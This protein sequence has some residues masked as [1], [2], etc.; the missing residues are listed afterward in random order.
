MPETTQVGKTTFEFPNATQLVATRLVKAPRN[1]VWQAH[2]QCEHIERWQIGAEGWWMSACEMDVR[3]G[4]SYRFVYSGPEGAGFQFT[5]VYREVEEPERLVNTERLDDSPTE[6]VNTLTL[7]EEEGGTLIR[8]VVDYPSAEVREQILATGMLD[9]WGSS[10]D[11]LEEYLA[12]A[13]VR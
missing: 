1:L 6:T 10:Y 9:G 2:T 4:G 13:V 8:T 7:S 11:A 3:P 5:G 12:S